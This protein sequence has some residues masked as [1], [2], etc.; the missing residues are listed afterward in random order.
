[1]LRYFSL[2]ILNNVLIFIGPGIML[3]YSVHCY[4][5]ASIFTD[6]EVVT[7][8]AFNHIEIYA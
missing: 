4:Q 1:M 8:V 3:G 7:A 6:H 5:S 2:L